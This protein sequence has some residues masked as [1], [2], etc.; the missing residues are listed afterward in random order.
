L[1]G[2]VDKWAKVIKSA[3]HQPALM[4][5]ALTSLIHFAKSALICAVQ[6]ACAGPVVDDDVLFERLCSV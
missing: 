2:S 4:P 1:I 5:V 6:T 3:G